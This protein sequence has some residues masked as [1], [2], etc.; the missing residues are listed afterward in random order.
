MMKCG[1]IGIGIMGRPQALNLMKAG[2]PMTVY[3]RTPSKCAPLVEAGARLAPSPA[4]V[5]RQSDVIITMVS[6]TPD[7][8]AVLFGPQG[9]A[10]GLTPGK[11]VIDMSTISPQATGEFACKLAGK[12][13]EM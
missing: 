8:E 1:F 11:I 5:A 4:E 13:C 12:G 10:E 7:V 2:F 6:D 9:V 3:N